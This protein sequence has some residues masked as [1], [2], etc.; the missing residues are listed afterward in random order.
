MGY[1]LADSKSEISDLKFQ[2]EFVRHSALQGVRLIIPNRVS[3]RGMINNG[4]GEEMRP[5]A[6]HRCGRFFD[7]SISFGFAEYDGA[8]QN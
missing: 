4:F 7:R 2:D 5:E 1:W 6:Q 3:I 8:S